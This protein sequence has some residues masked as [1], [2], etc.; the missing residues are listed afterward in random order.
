MPT[1]VTH[2]GLPH[3]ALTVVVEPVHEAFVADGPG[4]LC[5]SE[6]I[7]GSGG[8]AVKVP[9]VDF[10]IVGTTVNVAAVGRRG[11]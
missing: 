8:G 2:D 5:S 11:G 7:D 9:D 10:A 3:T 4:V 1:G 6:D